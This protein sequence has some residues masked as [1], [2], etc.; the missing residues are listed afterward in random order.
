MNTVE[1]IF[2][3][4]KERNINQKTFASAIGISQGNV[5]DWKKGRS[6]PSRDVLTRISCYLN[7]SID[8]LLGNESISGTDSFLLTPQEEELILCYRQATSDER[9]I[10]DTTLKKYRTNPAASGESVV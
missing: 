7:V 9:L 4:L 1:K 3:I 8:Y 5:T 6:N 2:S 10:V